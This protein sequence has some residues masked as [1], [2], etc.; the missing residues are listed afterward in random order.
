[1]ITVLVGEDIDAAASQEEDNGSGGV[2]LSSKK[3]VLPG[4]VVQKEKE[5]KCLEIGTGRAKHNETESEITTK[6][7]TLYRTLDKRHTRV[8]SD[9]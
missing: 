6:K 4:A 7:T 5:T 2:K 9:H 1:M 3:T 8:S